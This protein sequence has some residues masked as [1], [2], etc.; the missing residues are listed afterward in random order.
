MKILMTP[1]V[2]LAALGLPSAAQASEEAR[3]GRFYSA[4]EIGMPQPEASPQLSNP[5]GR[6][7]LAVGFGR[8]HS[9]HLAWEIDYL[10]YGQSFDVLP[11][12]PPLP[13]LTASDGRAS[14]DTSSISGTLRLVYPRGAFEPYAGAGLGYYRAK[15][16]VT[17]LQLLFFPTSVSRR[18][19][20]I[21]THL[22]VGADFHSSAG[23][24]WGIKYRKTF[25][26]A[27]F[28]PEIPGEIDLGAGIWTL[29]FRR[30]F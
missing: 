1:V 5:H 6:V 3:I 12:L 18:E 4:F 7:A 22:M 20:G 9:R 13:P 10:G 11:G 19:S 2:A 26:D 21:G 29:S 27:A 23:S 16:S 28:G 17:G 25:F 30:T 8:R 15:L 24:A 14:A